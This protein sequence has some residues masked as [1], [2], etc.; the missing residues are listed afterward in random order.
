MASLVALSG[1]LADATDAAD[2]ALVR[3][4]ERWERLVVSGDPAPWVFR[5]G[6]NLLRRRQRRRAL[7]STLLR[8]LDR[9]DVLPPPAGEVWLLVKELSDRQ[10][11]VIVLRFVADLAEADIAE[12][13]RVSRSTVSSTLI[14][15]KAKLRSRLGDD[16]EVVRAR[17]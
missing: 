3:A 15:A 12:V 8:K 7:E 14:D 2:E 16:S 13:L 10:R 5:V 9:S 1:D 6:V 11:A 4:Y 17:R